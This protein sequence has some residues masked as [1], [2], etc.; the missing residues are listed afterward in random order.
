MQFIFILTFSLSLYG[1]NDGPQ[2]YSI[3]VSLLLH[4]LWPLVKIGYPVFVAALL[5]R[6]IPQ[7]M[8]RCALVGRNTFLWRSIFIHPPS[9]L[10]GV[11][12]K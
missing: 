3:A 12:L 5:L 4:L 9:S 10:P 8:M 7:R 1:S 6:T 2:E 11:S